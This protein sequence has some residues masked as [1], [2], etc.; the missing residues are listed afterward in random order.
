MLGAKRGGLT[1]L[2]R[3][4]GLTRSA[5]HQWKQVPAHRL[6]EVERIT[7]IPREALRPDLYTREPEPPRAMS[8]AA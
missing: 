8:A 6:V 1:R 5:V 3:A 4:L 7:G 2:A